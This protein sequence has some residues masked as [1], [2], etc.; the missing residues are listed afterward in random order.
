VSSRVPALLAVIQISALVIAGCGYRPVE[1]TLPGG[2]SSVRVVAPNPARTDDPELS[3][4]LAAELCREL[5][6]AGIK[7]SSAG[8]ADAILSTKIL[9]VTGQAPVVAPGR[10]VVTGQR[11]SLRLELVLT[12]RENRVLWRSGLLEV[13]QLWPVPRDALSA[14]AARR[15]TLQSLAADAARQGVER[16]LSGVD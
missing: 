15:R 16:L 7:V 11:L 14:S 13:E 3:R 9:T 1:G 5:G 8:G 4:M 2:A 6:S 12:S 10:R